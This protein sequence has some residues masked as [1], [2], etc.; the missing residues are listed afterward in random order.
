[1]I[2]CRI[3]LTQESHFDEPISL[4]MAST[5]VDSAGKT[6]KSTYRY[7]LKLMLTLSAHGYSSL[8]IDGLNMAYM[9]PVKLGK[10]SYSKTN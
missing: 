1:M 7:T 4:Q 10:A 8:V 9:E 3:D 6:R 5:P 2:S